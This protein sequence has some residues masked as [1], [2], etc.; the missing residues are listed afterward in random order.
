MAVE[1]EATQVGQLNPLFALHVPL[2]TTD[3]VG[4]LTNA[5]EAAHELLR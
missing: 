2:L 3:D 5:N 4:R 1:V